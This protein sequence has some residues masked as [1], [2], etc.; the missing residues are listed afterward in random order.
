[1]TEKR[2]KMFKTKN[3][4]VLLLSCLMLTGCTQTNTSSD[5]NILTNTSS[6]T[7]TENTIENEKSDVTSSFGDTNADVNDIAFDYNSIPAYTDTPY[8]TINNNMAYFTKEEMAHAEEVISSGKTYFDT[9]DEEY[10]T[11][12]NLGRCRTATALLSTKTMPQENEERGQIGIVKPSGWQTITYPE[13]ISDRYLYNRCHLIGWQLGNEN[14]NKENL[15][16]GTRYMNVDGMLP[17]ENQTADYIR[18]TNNHVLYRVTPIFI[19]NELVC[20]GVLM[21]AQSIEDNDLSFCVFCYNVQPQIYIDYSTGESYML[22]YAQSEKDNTDNNKSR[23]ENIN[24]YVLN[25]NSL[26][27]HTTDCASIEK[28]NENN[29]S[30]YTGSIND[31]IENGYEKCK[32]CNPD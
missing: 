27:I 28:M 5:S 24:T 16:T 4:I 11:F 26:K 3:T 25:T 1:M 23:S 18:S 21:E 30:E 15:V 22:E 6:L 32:I 9:D 31:L 14:A 12:D 10:L 8:V 19:D 17:F 20:R 29:K 7:I 2:I 13:V